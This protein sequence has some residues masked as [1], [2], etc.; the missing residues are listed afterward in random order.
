MKTLPIL[1]RTTRQPLF[2]MSFQPP[3][4]AHALHELAARGTVL[5][6]A[7]LRGANMDG[8]NL[9]EGLLQDC[10]L[11]HATLIGACLCESTIINCDFTGVLC[12]GADIA[13]AAIEGCLFTTLSAMQMNFHE[14][15]NI[16]A[17][18]L[19]DE[20]TGQLAPF[21]R[22]PV[23]IGGLPQPLIIL[24]HDVRIGAH[25]VA[26]DIWQA[27]AND[28]RPGNVTERPDSGVYQLVRRHA[29]LLT[30]L[31]DMGLLGI[32]QI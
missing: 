5:R 21:S 18:A 24:D 2:D 1:H 22:A 25:L 13:G 20:I 26:H 4:T 11:A 31:Y 29:R 30:A 16:T 6:D 23:Y 8:A 9:S 10:L 17:C 27:I 7:D 14:S 28:N 3:S 19:R 32:G 15:A 12:G